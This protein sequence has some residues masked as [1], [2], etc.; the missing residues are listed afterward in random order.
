MTRVMSLHSGTPSGV[1]RVCLAY[2]QALCAAP[3]PLFGLV[4]TRL[5]YVLLDQ[6][7]VDEIRLRLEGQRPWGPPDRLSRLLH[8]KDQYRRITEA[9][10]RRFA[11]ARCAP[12]FLE[13]MLHRHLPAG[14]TYVNVEQNNMPERLLRAVA[15]LDGGRVAAF[16]HDTIPLD[17]PHTQTPASVLRFQRF[18]QRAQAHAEVILCNSQVSAADIRRHMSR[19]GKVPRTVVAHLGVQD[20]FFQIGNNA[21]APA[22]PSPYFL[23]LGTIEPRKNHRFLLD[24]W[25]QLETELAPQQM[26]H[27]VICGRRGWLN[28]DLFQR[29]DA[30]PLRGRFLHEF[31]G[32]DDAALGP[33]MAHAAGSLFPSLAEGFGL[34]PAE[35]AAARVP[36]ICNDLPIFRET[37]GDIPIYAS[38]TDSYAWKK[39]IIDL[40]RQAQQN[41][42][43]SRN[44]ARDHRLPDWTEHFNV[45]LKVI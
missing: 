21:P 34:P 44:R 20:D 37:L 30:S 15:A 33:L 13:R 7:G 14:T 10:L 43:E 25:E 26:P 8:R 38:V 27:L 36:V 19:W 24:L 11:I 6:R 31:N 22:I 3:Q 28:E 35:A 4:R 45:A 2:V 32:L 39:S 5:G 9:E 16:V 18:L 23:C 29:L 42:N 41:R 40:A 17:L 1:D 12:A